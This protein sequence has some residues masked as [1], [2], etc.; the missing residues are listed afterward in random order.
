MSTARHPLHAAARSNESP[1]VITAL[2]EA[3]ADPNAQKDDEWTPLHFAALLNE[4]PAVI[5][6]LLEAGADP[7]ARNEN[8]VTPLH[9]ATGSTKNAWIYGALIEAGEEPE[10]QKGT[11]AVVTVTTPARGWRGSQHTE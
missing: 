11:P 7:N 10:E 5:A 3:G 6:A 1:A 9:F 4:N 2:L 8:D